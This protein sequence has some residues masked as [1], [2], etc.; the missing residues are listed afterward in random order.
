MARQHRIILPN[1]PHHVVHRGH[2]RDVIFNSNSDFNTYLS[3]M[4]IFRDLLA[5]KIYSFCLMPNHVHLII[6]PGETPASISLFMMRL[7]GRYTWHKNTRRGRRGTLWDGRFRSN[8]VQSDRYLQT[9]CRYVEMNPVRANIVD[10]PSRY[11]WSSF[12]ER[13]GLTT[14]KW[15]DEDPCYAEL[16]A[17]RPDREKRYKIWFEQ[18]TTEPDL[19]MIQTTIRRGGMIA[20]EICISEK[21]E[22]TGLSLTAKPQGRPARRQVP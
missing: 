13:I 12:R 2:N 19:D 10:H 17:N 16:G 5:V 15:L 11:R 20:E 18:F 8:P 4:K 21:E 1:L 22:E 3:Y 14:E 6:D 7:A 9:C